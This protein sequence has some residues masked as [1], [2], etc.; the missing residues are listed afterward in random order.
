M[1]RDDLDAHRFDGH[2]PDYAQRFRQP[3]PAAEVVATYGS[4]L[5]I[6]D[7]WRMA[8]P[9]AGR[10]RCGEMP[11]CHGR[12]WLELVRGDGLRVTGRYGNNIDGVRSSLSRRNTAV[13][14]RKASA[15]FDIQMTVTNGWSPCRYS[16]CATRHTYMCRTPRS[17][18]ISQDTALK[19]REAVPA[20]V[21]P[22]AQWLAFNQQLL[23]GEASLATLNE[24]TTTT[25]IVFFADG[26]V[27]YT[28]TPNSSMIY[29]RPG[30]HHTS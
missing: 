18:R 22:T 5:S 30:W 1:G 4:L 12:R 27:K 29:D 28:N 9:V 7:Y 13:V 19:L 2:D 26:L 21:K 15:L 3:K 16:T 20:H 14:M 8:L 23:Q 6:P 24:H 25:E 17:A 11:Y 10:C